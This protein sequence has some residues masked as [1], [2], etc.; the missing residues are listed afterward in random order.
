M[1]NRVRDKATRKRKYWLILQLLIIAAIVAALIVVLNDAI[2]RSVYNE[3]KDMLSLVTD[4]AAD[5]VGENVQ[6]EWNTV[7][8]FRE[9]VIH[10]LELTDT[11]EEGIDLINARYALD[12][13]YFFLVDENG[14]YYCSDGT[15]GKLTDMSYFVDNTEKKSEYLGTLPHMDPLETYMIFLT[16][17]EEPVHVNS[18]ERGDTNILYVAY[19]HSISDLK[20][21]I[22]ELFPGATNIFIYDS[23]GAMLYKEFGISLLIEGYNIFPK[24]S[25]SKIVYGEDP[26]ALIEMC[27]NG[28]DLVVQLNIKAVDYYFCSS[29]LD[30]LDWSLAF[31]VQAE[32]VGST[33]TDSFSDIILYISLLAIVIG[34]VLVIVIFVSVRRKIAAERLKEAEQLA[35]ALG[36]ASK[37]KTDFLSNM[38]HDIR[39]P[40]NGIMGMTNIAKKNINDKE[41]LSEC[42]EK[43]D[44]ASHHLLS[45]VNDV[46]DMS[47]IE[48]GKIEITTTPSDIRTLCDNCAS[49][50][51]GQIE[52]R[53]LEF[54]Q[55]VEAEHPKIYADE[56][57]LRQVLIN[58][59]GN[60]VKFT[61]DGGKIRFSCRET[62]CDDKNVTYRFEIQDSGIGMSRE[63]IDHIYEA[64]AQEAGGDRTQYK[65]T[66]LGMSIAKQFVDL[67]G[68]KIEIESALGEGTTFYVTI[69]FA[70]DT[71]EH[72]D[73]RISAGS[74]DIKGVKILLAEDNELN[75]EIAVDLFEE[76]GAVVDTAYNGREAFE[77]FTESPSGTYDVVILDVMMP[78]MNGL[79]AARAIRNCGRPDAESIP[80]LAMTANAFEDDIRATREAGM[81]AHLSKPIQIDE[82]IKTIALYASK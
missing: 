1:M 82:V 25:Q 44:G 22:A 58:I 8:I 73:D 4:M 75:M 19:G 28:E 51:N 29:K 74:A 63:F 49:V 33:G 81:N 31:I 39:T 66:G 62:V 52:E 43:I 53:D 3:R 41:R 40:I 42:L 32:Y 30:T 6:M 48:R 18:R 59:L 5:I 80:I 67:M 77:K 45:L 46:L 65:G 57:H 68:G 2:K 50:I 24:F 61:R 35:D 72:K 69:T 9:T 10:E 20:E 12:D 15:F 23:T 13:E 34:L 54:I 36:E 14:K 26:D 56:L 60:A 76:K 21:K 11:V 27:K 71:K 79:E 16:E 64:F 47:R 17:L 55:E 78:E 7:D 70:R 38:S 37:A